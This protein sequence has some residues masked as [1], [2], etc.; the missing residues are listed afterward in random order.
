MLK[1]RVGDRIKFR[2][3]SEEIWDTVV[4]VACRCGLDENGDLISS[5]DYVLTVNNFEVDYDSIID[6]KH[7]SL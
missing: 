3:W 7:E 6:I 5:E 1:V 4:Q 2:D